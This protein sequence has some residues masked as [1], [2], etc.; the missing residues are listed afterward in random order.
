VRITTPVLCDARPL[1]AVFK[2]QKNQKT[3]TKTKI[4]VMASPSFLT[5][6]VAVWESGKLK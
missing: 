2:K 5:V 4:A 6:G 1:A 3:K